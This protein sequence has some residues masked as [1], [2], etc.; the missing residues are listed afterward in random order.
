MRLPCD[1]ENN[2][3]GS[4][5]K[6]GRFSSRRRTTQKLEKRE[7]FRKRGLLSKVAMIQKGALIFR[8]WP[9]E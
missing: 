5:K 4:K 7:R 6:D 3:G 9:V 1:E 2:R 8:L